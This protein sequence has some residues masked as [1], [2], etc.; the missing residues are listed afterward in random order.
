MFEQII[1]FKN[2][3]NAYK[4]AA[5]VKK[6]RLYVQEYDYDLEYNL[7][8]LQRNLK[9]GTYQWGEYKNFY[10]YDPKKRLIAAAPFENRIVHHAICNIIEPIFEK[11]FISDSYACRKGKGTHTALLRTFEFIKETNYVLKADIS[12][13]FNSIN[14]QILFSILKKKI[15]DTKLLKLLEALIA[16]GAQATCL[17][18]QKLPSFANR[19]TPADRGTPIGN[20]TSQLFA[21]IYLNELDH[22]LK[23][24]LAIE[25]YIRY[26][27]DFVIFGQN[28]KE[29]WQTAKKIRAFLKDRLLL[30]LHPKKTSV[31]PTRCAL[32]FLGYK[33]YPEKILLRH[34]NLVNFFKRRKKH[35]RWLEKGV[36]TEA[37]THS[38][39][40][41]LGIANYLYPKA[42]RDYWFA[43]LFSQPFNTLDNSIASVDKI[44]YPF[45]ERKESI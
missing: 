3:L 43:E 31:S 1:S 14:G 37:L 25:H 11:T 2:I 42:L 15:S 28:K 23:D 29:L 39:A 40:S 38:R 27:D 18:Q 35:Q 5:K 12:R 20:L 13:Y 19:L 6:D 45:V 24:K 26:M 30:S 16:S 8:N 44:S 41:F 32:D 9:N 33:I 34:R 7:L 10:V 4:K 22:F 21:N 36:K 17:S